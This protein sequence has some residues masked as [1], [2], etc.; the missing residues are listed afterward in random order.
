MKT[1]LCAA[2]LACTLAPLAAVAQAQPVQSGGAATPT[3]V[4]SGGATLLING[5]TTFTPPQLADTQS[6]TVNVT[7][8]GAPSG[9]YFIAGGNPACVSQVQILGGQPGAPPY[10]GYITS[11]GKF[12]FYKLGPAPHGCI[13]TITSSSGGGPTTISF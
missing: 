11:Y 10:S 6:F 5:N 2:A 7:Q 13:V 4:Q 3:N 8:P 12:T 9:T 1:I